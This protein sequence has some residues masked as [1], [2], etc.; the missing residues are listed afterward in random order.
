MQTNEDNRATGRDR[1]LERE[2]QLRL[3]EYIKLTGCSKE[4][5]IQTH[6]FLNALIEKIEKGLYV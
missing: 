3:I 2:A 1:V 4:V 5:P 6:I